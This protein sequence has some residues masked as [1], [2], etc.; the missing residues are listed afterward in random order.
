MKLI[1]LDSANEHKFIKINLK[2]SMY[3]IFLMAAFSWK[4]SFAVV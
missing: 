3:Y 2:Y 4:S 1:I